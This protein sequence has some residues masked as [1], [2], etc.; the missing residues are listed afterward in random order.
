MIMS[1]EKVDLYNLD[2]D[3]SYVLCTATKYQ[4]TRLTP[5]VS[6]VLTFECNYQTDHLLTQNVMSDRNI[7]SNM[8]QYANF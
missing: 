5:R 6:I 3:H 2:L 4:H 1:A 7:C 8:Q